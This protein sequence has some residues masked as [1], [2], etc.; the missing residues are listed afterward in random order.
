MSEGE[1]ARETYEP[2]AIEILGSV[3]FLT[4]GTCGPRSDGLGG[5][6]LGLT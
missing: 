1:E 4:A 6:L 5:T 3:E 2:P